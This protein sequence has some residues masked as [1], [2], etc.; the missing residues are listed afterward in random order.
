MKI[1]DD[2]NPTQHNYWVLK[3]AYDW[4]GERLRPG[5]TWVNLMEG[6]RFSVNGERVYIDDLLR[7]AMYV[8]SQ[9]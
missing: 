9:N 3:N 6:T 2:L 7:A 5:T 8:G 4:D 1:P